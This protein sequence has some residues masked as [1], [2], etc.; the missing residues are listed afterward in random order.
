MDIPPD[1]LDSFK[2][3]KDD[4]RGALIGEIA[5]LTNEA[6]EKKHYGVWSESYVAVKLSLIKTPLLKDHF[7]Q[8]YKNEIFDGQ[9]FWGLLKPN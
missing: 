3:A 9:K 2:K 7:Y 5:K 6:R 4:E 1:Y 8:C